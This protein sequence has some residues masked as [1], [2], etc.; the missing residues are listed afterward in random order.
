ME[1]SMTKRKKP[2]ILFYDI[3]PW[4]RLEIDGSNV[5]VY[6]DHK[7]SKGKELSQWFTHD[8]YRRTKLQSKT[9]TI[10]SIVAEVA[11]GPRPQGMVINHKDGNKLNNHP[12]NLEYCT[13]AEN[14]AHSIK[15]GMHVANDP[16]RNGNY[17]DGRCKDLNPYKLKW[18]HLNK[19]RLKK[20]KKGAY[21]YLKKKG[22]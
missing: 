13:I 16:K 18:Y 14:I 6:S 19:N 5:R 21:S 2:K 3:A 20:E 9:R 12:S 11:I 1:L 8:G 17:K 10:H 4:Y 15:H 22:R 7:R